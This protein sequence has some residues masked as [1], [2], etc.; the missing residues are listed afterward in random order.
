MQAGS[1]AWC[2]LLGFFQVVSRPESQPHPLPR[3]PRVPGC[4][5]PP[6]VKP[7][8]V[9]ATAPRCMPHEA[10]GPSLNVRSETAKSLASVRTFLIA[11]WP[12]VYW[13]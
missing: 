5:V 10:S 8:I 9:P 7:S 11:V 6:P 3:R 4:G 1:V 13:V 2:P 12:G